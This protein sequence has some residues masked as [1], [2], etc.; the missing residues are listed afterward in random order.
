MT[1]TR[2]ILENPDV[3][4]L[5]SRFYAF[6][7]GKA[8]SVSIERDGRAFVV[9]TAP[10]KGHG[11]LFDKIDP[12]IYAQDVLAAIEIESIENF[13]AVP[14]DRPS[15]IARCLN[16]G[17]SYHARLYLEPKV[18]TFWDPLPL[19]FPALTRV[20]DQVIKSAGQDPSVYRV[21]AWANGVFQMTPA[22]IQK[23]GKFGPDARDHER[24]LLVPLNQI[25]QFVKDM[26]M[27]EQ[28]LKASIEANQAEAEKHL[29]AAKGDETQVDF[30][31]LRGHR[32]FDRTK[33]PPSKKEP[34]KGS[35]S[36]KQQD[37]AR[38]ADY[39]TIAQH[40]FARAAES[41]VQSLIS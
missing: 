25:N 12:E 23:Y 38:K 35:G 19:I 2:D 7:K 15:A 26:S 31:L 29:A 41:V 22:L 39:D 9:S 27:S 1:R 20:V 14:V 34:V 28:E 30:D 40:R 3:L 8:I 11:D 18:I 17:T 36:L 16:Y 5:K 32:N 10:D 24:Q 21:E 37:V 4:R 33:L 13:V 6:D